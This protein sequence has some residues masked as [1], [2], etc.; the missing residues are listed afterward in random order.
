MELESLLGDGAVAPFGAA[1]FVERAVPIHQLGGVVKLGRVVYDGAV[2]DFGE[3]PVDVAALPMREGKTPFAVSLYGAGAGRRQVEAAGLALKKRLRERGSVRLVLPISGASVSAAGLKHNRVLEDGFELLV[4]VAGKRM[5]VAQTLGVQD[6]DWYSQR[7]Y[8]RPER[9]ARVGMLPPKLAQVL[10]N[11]TH[12]PVVADPFCGSGVVLAEALIAGRSACGS[13]LEAEMVAAARTNLQWLEQQVR[14][15]AP[16]PPPLPDWS[17]TAADA[18][19]VMLP[20]ACAVVSEGYLGTPFTHSPVP[21]GL[22]RLQSELLELYTSA[23]AHWATQLA[24]GAEVSLCVPTWRVHGQWRPLGLVDELAGLGYTQKVF[25]HVTT[26]LLYAR[27]DQVVGRQ[28]L[29]LRKG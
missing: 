26:P 16:Q 3:L 17:V 1:A 15:R 8:G 11:T 2:T 14:L 23:L 25:K 21:A 28:L 22:A 10:V 27:E 7:D 19:A 13:D 4:V 9:D 20:P 29:F 12:A 18:R 5:A 24:P 6:V